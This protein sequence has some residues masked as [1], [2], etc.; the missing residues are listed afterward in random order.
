M[1]LF[2]WLLAY[3]V[4]S[5]VFQVGNC[6]IRFGC[7]RM[8]SNCVGTNCPVLIT[9]KRT[10]GM[11]G[12]VD[13]EMQTNQQYIALGHNTLPLM[14]SIISFL[15]QPPKGVLINSCCGRFGGLS[16]VSTF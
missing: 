1:G 16:N 5:F 4:L 15:K 13:I 10:R 12:Y 8:P 7:I 2:Y 6:G 9:Y 11:P 14:V 3:V